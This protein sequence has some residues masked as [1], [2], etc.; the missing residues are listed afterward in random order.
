MFCISL[1]LSCFTFHWNLHCSY[2]KYW[3]MH[4]VSI[5]QIVD[6]LDFNDNGNYLIKRQIERYIIIRIKCT[7]QVVIFGG[8]RTIPLWTIVLRKITLQ[9]IAPGTIPPDN[10]SPGNCPDNFSRLLIPPINCPL[11]LKCRPPDKSIMWI[12][13]LFFKDFYFYLQPLF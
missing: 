8:N 13:K 4:A 1:V 7:D 5:S 12:A 9:L 2:Q 11:P 3:N 10:H 6:I